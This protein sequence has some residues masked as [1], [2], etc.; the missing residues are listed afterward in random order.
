MF[1]YDGKAVKVVHAS[2][3]RDLGD[4]VEIK[5]AQSGDRVVL[6]AWRQVARR[7][8][9]GAG[10]KKVNEGGN[11]PA[12][13]TP[14]ALP[15]V[16]IRNP[17]NTT[18]AA[19]RMCQCSPTSRSISRPGIFWRSWG[20]PGSGKS[21][22]LNL[23]AGIDK[24]SGGELTV[25]G[26]NIAELT[27]AELAD[28][29]AANVGFVFQFYNL[30]P[31]LT[32]VENVELPLMLTDLPRRERRERGCWRYHW[33]AA[34]IRVDHYPN[35]LSGGQQQRVAIARALITDPT[36]IVADEPTGDLDKKK[37]LP[38]CWHCAATQPRDGQDDHHG[39]ARPGAVKAATTSRTLKKGELLGTERGGDWRLRCRF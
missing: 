31:V 32:A 33:S 39:D 23:I 5:W 9:G 29:R 26:L 35:E 38:T 36:L 34:V 12:D 4:S 20:R 25:G 15:L 27:E 7:R 17:A 11:M 18:S 21:T 22:L 16:R 6:K 13:A 19:S 30:M 8:C 3:G 10:G 24:P 28:W 14:A 1:V 37:T 2:K